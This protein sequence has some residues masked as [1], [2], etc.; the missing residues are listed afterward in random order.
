MGHPECAPAASPTSQTEKNLQDAVTTL[1]RRINA[2]LALHARDDDGDCRECGV[3]AY[4]EAIAW[5]CATVAALQGDQ[6]ADVIQVRGEVDGRAMPS[7]EV[8]RG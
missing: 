7:G 4:G 1:R 5:P 8:D 2:A 3:D 6:P